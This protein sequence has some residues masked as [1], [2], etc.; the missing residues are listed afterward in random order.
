MYENLTFA[1]NFLY[2]YDLIIYLFIII[3]LFLP[4]IKLLSIYLYFNCLFSK[5]QYL[6]VLLLMF[7]FFEI[8]MIKYISISFLTIETLIF[9]VV[10]VEILPF[11]PRYIKTSLQS[12][13]KKNPPHKSTSPSALYNKYFQVDDAT[14]R[15]AAP[16]AKSAICQGFVE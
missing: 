7:L 6:L 1:P 12:Q 15:S 13:K 11:L 16:R 8:H 14:R 9:F 5:N 10:T 3:C 2:T 4:F